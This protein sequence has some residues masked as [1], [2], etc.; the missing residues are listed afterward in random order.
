MMAGKLS[1]LGKRSVSHCLKQRLKDEPHFRGFGAFLM[2]TNPL[3]AELMGNVGY[4]FL[5]V[6]MEHSPADVAEALPM[7]QATQAAQCPTLLRVS[8]PNRPELIKKAL[9]LGPSGLV[10]PLVDSAVDARAIV[11]ACRYPTKGI[12]GV[13]HSIVR[14]SRWGLDTDYVHSAEERQL[15]LCQ[16]ETQAA[17]EAVDEILS[18]DGVDGIFVGP[19]DLSAALGHLGDTGHKEV[20]AAL[21]KVEAAAAKHPAK[22]LAGFAG[23]RPV[24]DMFKAGYRLVANTADVVLLREAALKDLRGGRDASRTLEESSS[25]RQKV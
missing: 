20:L 18:V 13:A 10:V 9:D 17:V 11:S 8:H 14:A 24:I 4:D 22:I 5:V 2:S 7:L 6:D 16:V 23:G 1:S 25:K 3:V 19:L 21:E 15:L 12:R